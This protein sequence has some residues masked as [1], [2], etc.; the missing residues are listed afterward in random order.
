MPSLLPAVV[1]QRH[2]HGLSDYRNGRGGRPARATRWTLYG[3]PLVAFGFAL[4]REWSPSEV[5]DA[6][7]GGYSLVAGVL[8]AAFA[9]LASW[10]N[11]LD[12]RARSRPKS[13]APARR[14]VD[15]A[16]AHCLVGV[17]AAVFAAIAAILSKLEVSPSCLWDAAAIGLG[18]YLVL[19]IMLIVS[20][21]F[22][23][24]E[25]SVDDSIQR[26]DDLLLDEDE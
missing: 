22:V 23:G 7:V 5:V 2:W 4:W 14:A 12:K 1:F 21:I 10:R 11:E 9:Q 19:L 20:A 18:T 25:S 15:A 24:Y 3:L 13:D 8:L 6:L 17:V 16:V 26:H